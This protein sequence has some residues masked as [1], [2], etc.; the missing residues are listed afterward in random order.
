M[1]AKKLAITFAL[2]GA[3]GSL[4]S[5]HGL[6]LGKVNGEMTF[7]YGHSGVDTDEYSADK[8]AEAYGFKAD[9]SKVDLPTK[10][11][12]NYVTADLEGVAVAVGVMDNGYWAKGKDG[13][14]VN[15][16][17][18]QVEGAESSA[19]YFKYTVAYLNPRAKVQPAGL[20][21]E[22]VPEV[23]PA[24]LEEGAELKVQVLY[25]GKPLEGVEINSNYFDSHSKNVSTDKE[26]YALV[27]VANH[28]FNIIAASHKVEG[29][30]PFDKMGYHTTL[31]FEAKHD[32]HHH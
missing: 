3:F 10:K 24:T 5:A 12:D 22:I 8:I 6:W 4:A 32:H 31:T 15:K 9:G 29:D 17:G 2:C 20:E 7:S 28:D 1:F 18:D 25:Q 30:N 21:L 27:P 13:K 23:N 26:G 11:Y 14:W 16:R 19:H